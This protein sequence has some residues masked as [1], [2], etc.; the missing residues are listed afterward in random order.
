MLK[1]GWGICIDEGKGVTQN[2]AEAVQ[3]YRK[4]ADQGHAK[5]QY[6]LGVMYKQG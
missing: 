3:W 6:N 5:G 2:K 4:A 1:S